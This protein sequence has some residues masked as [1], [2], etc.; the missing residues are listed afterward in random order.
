MINIGPKLATA[1]EFKGYTQ[2]EVADLL[3]IP[4]STWGSYELGVRE[5]TFEMLDRICD[6]LDLSISWLLGG[7]AK[8]TGYPRHGDA[9]ARE[10]RDQLSAIPDSARGLSEMMLLSL[11]ERT[12]I[13]RYRACSNDQKTAVR[14][15]LGIDDKVLIDIDERQKIDREERRKIEKEERRKLE[16]KY[17]KRQIGTP[18]RTSVEIRSL[19][20]GGAE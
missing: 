9:R 13:R 15:V 20:R 5:P 16:A 3:Q 6:V 8:N 4:R 1:R 19:R 18:G 14:V 2:Q 7:E 12:V 17:G 10:F 11:E